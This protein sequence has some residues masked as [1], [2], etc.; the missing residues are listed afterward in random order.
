MQTPNRIHTAVIQKLANRF[1]F[2][3]SLISKGATG[4]PKELA[5]RL[6][7]TERAWHKIRDE[8][9]NDLNLP[10]AYDPIRKTYYYT[11]AGQ[12]VFEFRRKLTTD[13]MEKLEGGRWVHSPASGTKFEFIHSLNW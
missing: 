1:R 4:S 11:E 9:V 12:L 6:G 13:D 3:D 10:L 5:E 2:L 8:L 7:I